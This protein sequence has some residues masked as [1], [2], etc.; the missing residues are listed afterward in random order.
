MQVHIELACNCH[1]AS[2]EWVLELPVTAFDAHQPPAI[3]LDKFDSISN[4]SFIAYTHSYVDS[5]GYLREADIVYNTNWAW[6]ADYSSPK[7]NSRAVDLQTMALHELGHV[8]GL[9]DLYLL[10]N[11]DS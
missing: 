6:T 4:V 5:S 3:G 9:G 10:P 8:T 11:T 2:F 1:A 7:A